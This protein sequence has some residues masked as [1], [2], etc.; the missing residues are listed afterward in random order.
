MTRWTDRHGRPVEFGPE[1]ARG[2]EGS[3]YELH[4]RADLVAKLYHSQA[5][6]SK[7]QKLAMMAEVAS[8]SLLKVAAWPV[9][10][11][12]EAGT[13]RI[14]GLLMPRVHGYK[15]V[16]ALYGPKQR[17]SD[18]PQA[19][20]EFLVWA[21]RNIAAAVETIQSQGHVIGDVNQKGFLV[22]PDATVRVIDCDSFQIMV[23]GKCFR[24]VVGVPE[25]TPP[26]LHGQSFDQ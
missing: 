19:D 23:N 2:G 20:W 17:L 11:I 18:F 26:E 16:H 4:N 15:E 7:G 5:D 13:R 12:M 14:G 8:P 9:D 24:S 21:A 25:F 10:V 22:S 1:I 3:V 6:P